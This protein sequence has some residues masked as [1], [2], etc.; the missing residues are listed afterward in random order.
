V[1]TEHN[2][3]ERYRWPTR[4]ANAV[5]YRR[6]DAV[7]AVSHAV[8]AS[9]PRR[10]SGHHETEVLLHGIEHRAMSRGETARAAAR[11]R[12]RIRESTFVIGSVGNFTPKKDQRTLLDA[13]ALVHQRI[14]DSVLLLVGSGPLEKDLRQHTA[15]LQLTDHVQFLGMRDDVPGLLPALD[16]F[17]LSSLHEGLSIALVEAMASGV[18]GVCTRVGGVPEVIT[19]D[20]NGRLVPPR[21]PRQL[22]N[23]LILLAEDPDRRHRLAEAAQQRSLDFDIGRAI[24][25]IEDISDDVLAAR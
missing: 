3:W 1:H 14:P 10:W 25:R 11:E 15:A 2:V 21:D 7:I 18:P 4:I 17:T 6:N 13:F 20:V 22:A 12:L 5:T 23:A 19:D 9:V 8:A 24:N 16:L